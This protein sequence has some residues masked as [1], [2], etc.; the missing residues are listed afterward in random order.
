[1]TMAENLGNDSAASLHLENPFSVHRAEH[2][3][4]DLYRYFARPELFSG[5]LGAKS[6]VVVG[7]RGC[8]KTMFFIYHTYESKRREFE[9]PRTSRTR[10]LESTNILGVYVHAKSD[11]VTAFTHRNLTD[12]DWKRIFGHY[13]NVIVAQ[14]IARIGSDIKESYPLDPQLERRA[15]KE[16]SLLLDL[17]PYAE[18]YGD[19][20]DRLGYV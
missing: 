20:A 13:F 7:G 14:Q 10:V 19:L 12:D 3:G 15:C 16:A 17:N 2:L 11:L 6:L 1:M 4:K 8:G 9:D 18:S 5:R